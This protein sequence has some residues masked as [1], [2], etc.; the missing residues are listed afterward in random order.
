MS[1]QV[2][3]DIL[4]K[5]W[6]YPAF[7]PMQWD[8]IE[9]VALQQDTFAI[10]P[11]GG[12]K[13][14]CYQVPALYFRGLTVVISPLIALME[15]QVKQLNFREVPSAY[16][17]SGLS[18]S[19]QIETLNQAISGEIKILYLAPERAISES[20]ETYW[21][22]LPLSFLA[23]DE[24]H[25]IS[26]WGHDFRP[27]YLKL[28]ELRA[29]FPK[30]PVLAV[31][32]SA[33]PYVQKDIV[34]YLDLHQ[35]TFFQ[36]SVVRP[37]LT[38]AVA[39]SEN[40]FNDIVDLCQ[41][42]QSTGIVYA[43][44]RKLTRSLSDALK[45]EH[46]KSS[47]YHAGLDLNQRASQQSIWMESD[48]HVMV[49]TNA[50]GMGIDK[51]N[52]RFVTH[53]ILPHSL[54]EY[55]QEA[56]RAGR[57]EKEAVAVLYYNHGDIDRLN[58]LAEDNFPPIPWIEEVYHRISDYLKVAVEA[59]LERTI[60]FSLEDFVAKQKLPVRKV[61]AAINLIAQDGYWEFENSA[62]SKDRLSL[63]LRS[64]DMDVLAQHYPE[65]EALLVTILRTY[66][67]VFN[68][69]NDIN[70]KLIAQKLKWTPYQ[71]HASLVRLT[72]MGYVVFQPAVTGSSITYLKS[73][74]HR[75]VFRLNKLKIQ[76]LK[77]RVI[78]RVKAFEAYILNQDTCRNRLI[79]DYFGQDA[80]A[81]K[82]C[83]KCDNCKRQIRHEAQKDYKSLIL[84]LLHENEVLDF[85]SLQEH[86]QEIPDQ[87]LSSLIR[88]LVDE[89]LIIFDTFH[90]IKLS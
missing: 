89:G 47:F 28:S 78:F 27:S 67:S 71:V 55:Y 18:Q 88:R 39:F 73:R 8:I 37:N 3:T 64:E 61:L 80:K 15:D 16:I 41:H 6:G 69:E 49:A 19:E 26:Q 31:T 81:V 5:Y 30:V 43:N 56:G 42:Y 51:P 9:S 83:G 13:S 63:K 36:Q 79:A 60:P 32:A 1:S 85:K 40:K 52:V 20:F 44:S 22:Q 12:G 75:Q 33:T 84:E 10:L 62:K 59:G 87:Q 70:L 53:L 17:H 86:L 74:Q 24:A 45:E 2:F 38:Y 66:G 57:D 58:R 77:E 82:P 54:E 90:K 11:T 46:I 34:K 29:Y 4:Q 23:I 65:F 14:L 35:V 68:F 21:Q 25:C 50:F 72:K 7:R 76:Q 48:E